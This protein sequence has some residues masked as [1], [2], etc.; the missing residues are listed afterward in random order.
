MTIVCIA[1]MHRSGTSMI[2][3]LLNLCGLYLGE[4]SDLAMPGGDNP[5]GFWENRRFVG[6]NDGLLDSLR[7]A[8]DV[9]PVLEPGWEGTPAVEPFR[10]QAA[11]EIARMA[12]RTPWGWKDPRNSLTL[13][14]WRGL[15]PG[16]KLVI[17][18]RSPNEVAGSLARRGY[19]SR[20]F[21]MNLWR[22]Y[23]DALIGAV[24][25][26]SCLITHYDG[27]FRAPRAE[28]QRL[29]AFLELEVPPQTL[30]EACASIR[31]ARRRQPPS[32]ALDDFPEIRER[33][34]HLCSL[35]GPVYLS[36]M[37][38]S[39]L[40]SSGD[41]TEAE[42]ARAETDSL[43]KNLQGRIW[44]AESRLQDQAAQI[45]EK[46]ANIAGMSSRLAEVDLQVSALADQ[47]SEIHGSRAWKTILWI[48][49]V[50][51]ILLPPR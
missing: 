50:R 25:E 24:R 7:G 2:T 21:S 36:G 46:D 4:E 15:I 38:E 17:C 44:Q 31:T 42:A 6:I 20:L 33:Y 3:R 48:R 18:L 8:W 39:D 19:A 27:Y 28:L 10:V 51:E 16:M 29:L 30:E 37:R 40:P 35:A 5:E 32:E 34:A 13:P 49:K 9:P 23:H 22:A 47:L 12:P 26:S 14:F 1:G 45:A 41:L 11:G 43:I